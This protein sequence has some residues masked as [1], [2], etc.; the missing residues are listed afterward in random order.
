MNDESKTKNEHIGE[1][2]EL[3]DKVSRL[4]KAK[5]EPCLP[6]L[7][8]APFIDLIEYT[9]DAMFLIDPETGRFLLV[10]DMACSNLGYDRDELLEKRVTDI[11]AILPDNFSWK[12]HTKA[13]RNANGMVLEGVHKR[14]GGSTFPAEISVKFT[15]NHNNR[16]M[17][18]VARDITRRKRAEE[19]L[20]KTYD[21]LEQIVEKRTE[22]LMQANRS[23]MESKRD[24]AIAQEITHLGHWKL[25]SETYEVIASDELLRIFGINREEVTFESLVE[26]VHPEDRGAD[27]PIFRKE[28]E[29]GENWDV[30]HRLCCK[31]GTEKVVHAVGNVISS[32]TGKAFKIIGTVQDIT[33]RKRNEDRFRELMHLDEVT[34]IANRRSY[35]KAIKNEWNRAK[36]SKT[37]LSIIMVDIDYFKPYNDTYGHAAGDDC[38]RHVAQALKTSVLRAGD[39]LARYGGEE[40]AVILPGSDKGAATTLGEILRQ[41]VE[42]LEI[43]HSGSTISKY[44][45]ISLGVATTVPGG[46]RD[47]HALA[48]AADMAL[49]RAKAE[50]RNRII[51]SDSI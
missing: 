49:Y 24:L 17:V 27:I 20:Q 38:L 34:G 29:S 1:L 19:T 13:V 18:A 46:A 43:E 28:V 37:P 9:N 41:N 44:V 33:E 30:E 2:A 7:D 22:E 4:K 31:D 8:L 47:H 6:D 3:R 45:T 40:F 12:K 50:G 15:H 5:A 10:N 21:E 25:D 35:E 42:S 32:E 51:V 16:Y 23:L 36:R 39:L 14:K 11:E 48:S 26:I